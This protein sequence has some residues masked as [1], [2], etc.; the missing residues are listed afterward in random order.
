MVATVT[1]RKQAN[2]RMSLHAIK[3]LVYDGNKFDLLSELFDR[4]VAERRFGVPVPRV[5]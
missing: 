4:N 5:N 1:L 2:Y 3:A